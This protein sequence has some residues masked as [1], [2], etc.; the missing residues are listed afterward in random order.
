LYKFGHLFNTSGINQKEIRFIARK[1]WKACLG[2]FDI[3][4]KSQIKKYRNSL[5]KRK[6]LFSG[7][8]M[9]SHMITS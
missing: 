3:K 8:L 7:N 9:D 1:N 5:S 2:L 6:K 4:K